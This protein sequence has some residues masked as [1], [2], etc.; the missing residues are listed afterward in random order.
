MN[1]QTIYFF[2]YNS[3]VRDCGFL[4]VVGKCVGFYSEDTGRGFL[5]NVGTCL[6]SKTT[7]RLSDSQSC[8]HVNSE[9]L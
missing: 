3:W 6:T 9:I 7:S 4:I 1:N 8:E 2:F 5:R